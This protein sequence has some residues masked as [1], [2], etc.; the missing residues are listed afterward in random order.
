VGVFSSEVKDYQ[1]SHKTQVYPA[2][3]H[4]NACSAS[5]AGAFQASDVS[6]DEV[7]Q[8]HMPQGPPFQS[9]HLTDGAVCVVGGQKQ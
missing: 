6:N 2:P 1:E 7:E 5:K 3:Y 4:V 8:S 9:D